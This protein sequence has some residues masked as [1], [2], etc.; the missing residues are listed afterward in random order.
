MQIINSIVTWLNFKRLYQIDLFKKFPYDA[1]REV[2][3]NLVDIAQKTEF[4]EKYDFSSID[5][6]EKFQERVPI[7]PYEEIKPFIDR[8]LKGEQNNTTVINHAEATGRFLYNKSDKVGIENHFA[9]YISFHHSKK[10]T[11]NEINSPFLN[12][13]DRKN[14]KFIYDL[15]FELFQPKLDCELKKEHPA[16]ML[17]INGILSFADWLVSSEEYWN[18]KKN[19]MLLQ[20]YYAQC[21]NDNSTPTLKIIKDSVFEYLEKAEILPKNKVELADNN[22]IFH[23]FFKHIPNFKAR[24][25]QQI[26][27]TNFIAD[28]QSLTIIEAPTGEGKTEAACH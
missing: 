13:A 15:Y 24:P 16:W 9:Q 14:I 3:F 18:T 2:L 11:I 7:Q 27:D 23:H 22:G 1:Q 28:K 10:F 5:S 25:L 12:K 21:L 19:G 6:I 4:G 8:L 20:D 26:V 17:I